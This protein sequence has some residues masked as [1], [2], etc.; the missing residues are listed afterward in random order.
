[1]SRITQSALLL[2]VFASFVVD[3]P[4]IGGPK[5][6][7][8][9]AAAEAS[10]AFRE[11]Q[12]LFEEADYLGAIESFERAYSLRPHFKVLCNI[13]LCNERIGDMV[14]SAKFYQRCLQDGAEKT[15]EAEAV[16]NT[17]KRVEARITWVEVTSAKGGTVYLD[18]RAMG[19]PPKRIPVNPGSR[20]IEVRLAGHAPTSTTIRTRGGEEH[21]LDLT[22]TLPTKG[23]GRSGGRRRPLSQVWFWSAAGLAA[24]CTIIATILGVKTLGIRDD[25]EANPSQELLDKGKSTRTAT[26][27]FWG[28]AAAAAGTATVLFFYTDF[29][30][31]PRDK[32]AAG[33]DR[34]RV[35]G[36]GVR[37]TF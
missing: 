34:E 7:S 20:V 2:V 1:M 25:Y 6:V 17:L 33:F 3:S 19:P 28:L 24:T 15:D 9:E 36:V 18:G 12:K 35:F 10:R 29:G 32:A 4:A 30:S 11:G 22:P 21:K 14:K 37:G 31:G 13:A 27:V 8:K 16:R 26:N 5:P 23:D